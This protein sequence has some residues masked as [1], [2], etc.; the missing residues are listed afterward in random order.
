MREAIK[1]VR[2]WMHELDGGTQRHLQ[3][4]E[5]REG[6]RASCH[7]CRSAA[8]CYQ[9]IEIHLFE[10]MAIAKRIRA[11]QRDT[12][13]FRER[14]RYLGVQ[15]GEAD[16][17]TWLNKRI[18]CAFLT[19]KDRCSIYR[20]RPLQCRNYYV[21]TDPELCGMPAGTEVRFMNTEPMQMKAGQFAQGFQ[22]LIGLPNAM[23]RV[24]YG[25]LPSLVLHALE[26]LDSL[27]PNKVLARKS[28]PKASEVEVQKIAKQPES[29]P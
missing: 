3:S 21:F 1:L 25:P 27:E 7:E 13:G 18:P 24:Y 20:D 14:L 16:T 26:A 19:S 17:A 5:R 4:I 22:K 23:G 10:A 9:K 8:C 28:W 11:E 12:P 6:K 15:M 2:K 29:R